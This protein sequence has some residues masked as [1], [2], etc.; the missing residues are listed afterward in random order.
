MSTM[1][2]VR[3]HT[4][5][6]PDVLTYE[7][8][9]RPV[10]GK[11]E[12]LIKVHATSV[13]PFDCATHAGYMA[14]YFP[15]PFPIVMGTDVSGEIEEVGEGVNTFSP[16]DEV[17][18]RAGVYRD[19]ANAEFVLASAADVT[20]KPQSLDHV[21][22]AALPHVTLAAWQALFEE[23]NLSKGQT[24]LIHAAAGGVGHIAVQLAKLMGANVIG[25][26]SQNYEFLEELGVDQAINYDETAFEKVAHNV[27]VVLDT[28]GADTQDRS[29]STLKPGGILVSTVQAPSAETGKA[30]NVRSAFVVTNP[31]IAQTL[32]RVAGLV[33]S[34]QLKPH[35]SAVLPLEEIHRAHQLLEARHTRGKVVLQVM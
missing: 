23:A 26:A 30:H 4:Y 27:D 28:I 15:Q 9:P 16:G 19:G 17:Y 18:T 5:G 1:N 22:A 11:G 2:A 6:G 14:S 13:N 21:H 24:I 25:T 8:A 34:G 35:V 7:S 3:I 29:W 10:P 12:V 20:A 31:P 33:D 32:N